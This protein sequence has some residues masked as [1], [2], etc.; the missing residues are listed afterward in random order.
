[1]ET[2]ENELPIA[3]LEEKRLLELRKKINND[4]SLDEYV[5]IYMN[6]VL[7]HASKIRINF[8]SIEELLENELK[9]Q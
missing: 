6:M 1:M 5:Y 2:K 9:E 7:T 8:N 4:K 3:T